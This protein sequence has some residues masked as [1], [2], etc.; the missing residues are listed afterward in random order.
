MEK[1]IDYKDKYFLYKNK[2]LNLKKLNDVG[3]T[4]KNLTKNVTTTDLIGGGITEPIADTLPVTQSWI[5][6]PLILAPFENIR[7]IFDDKIN[8]RLK[9][10]PNLLGVIDSFD[11][12]IDVIRQFY[13]THSVNLD[14]NMN[15]TK[16]N[17]VYDSPP[18]HLQDSS[19]ITLLQIAGVKDRIDDL[20]HIIF[21]PTHNVHF[22]GLKIYHGLKINNYTDPNTNIHYFT[23]EYDDNFHGSTIKRLIRVASIYT[24]KVIEDRDKI[25]QGL[26]GNDIDICIR[27]I[28]DPVWTQKDQ[29]LIVFGGW[30]DRHNNLYTILKNYKGYVIYFSDKYN[31]WYAPMIS[32]YI[33]FI[34]DFAIS[35][36]NYV[37][38]GWSMGGYGSLHA[39]VYFPTKQCICISL[40]PQTITHKKYKNIIIKENADTES[41][42]DGP[43]PMIQSIRQMYK[44]IPTIL[45]EKS[46]YTTK[47]YTLIGKSECDDFQQHHTPLYL[48]A[49]HIG[50]IINYPNVS[51]IIYNIAS[52]RLLERLNLIDILNIVSAN[53]DLLFSNQNEGNKLLSREIRERA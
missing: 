37:F 34:R 20:L 45:T 44:D 31:E 16:F 7:V 46:G 52:H 4:D 5:Y 22:K 53:F 43:R 27:N 13:I 33:S 29:A 48:D 28:N 2:Y 19:Q 50:V 26:Q 1:T 6:M 30:G 49:L 23:K 51:T 42:I 10:I 47:I 17:Y 40:V 8:Q 36:N 41:V 9:T 32:A 14:D 38:L 24:D 25:R 18:L 21:S 11:A 3:K 39:S 35:I 15:L 12:I